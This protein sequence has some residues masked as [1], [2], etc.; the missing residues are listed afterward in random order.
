MSNLENI[1]TI[2]LNSL[3]KAELQKDLRENEGRITFIK[4]DGTERV[5]HCTLMPSTLAEQV[6]PYEK[7]TDRVKKENPDV[8]AV[9][10]LEAQGWRSIN[11]TTITSVEFL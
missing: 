7:K 9:L 1:S 6:E 11:I 5:M 4:K 3:T 2:S 10:D 8:L